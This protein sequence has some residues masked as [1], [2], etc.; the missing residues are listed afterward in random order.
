SLHL[1]KDTIKGAA[2]ILTEKLIYSKEDQIKLKV[3]NYVRVNY[4]DI[5]KV[6]IDLV[7]FIL[8]KELSQT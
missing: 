4:K 1:L 6:Y 3:K 2:K 8:Y 5:L 7:E